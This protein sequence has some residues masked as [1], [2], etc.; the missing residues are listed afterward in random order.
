MP[1]SKYMASLSTRTGADVVLRAA[2][3]ISQSSELY[4]AHRCQDDITAVR[5]HTPGPYTGL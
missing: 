3:F 5:H 1:L 4:N 2:R